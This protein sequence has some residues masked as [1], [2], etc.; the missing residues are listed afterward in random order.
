MAAPAPSVAPAPSGKPPAAAGRP[1]PSP[2][3]AMKLPTPHHICPF[4]GSMNDDANKPCP[5]CTL[6]DTPAMRQATKDRIG[7]WYVLQT[8]NPAA[9][10]MTFATLQGLVRKGLVT[11]RSVV[12]GPTTHQ[13]WRWA[14]KVKG[15]S[16]EFGLCYG[17]GARIET[18]SDI[19]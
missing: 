17:C 8:R 7:P 1:A 6:E 16:R 19:C 18:N 10:G 12:R 14:A 2:A 15:L 4:C 9:P 5:R 13:L 3:P 11:P